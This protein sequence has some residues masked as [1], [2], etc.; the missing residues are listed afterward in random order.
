M[1]PKTPTEEIIQAYRETGSVWAA[2][3]RLG[4]CGQSVW[5]RLRSMGYPMQK[6]LWTAAEIEELRA[7]VGTMPLG[8]VAKRLGR[9]YT[10]VATRASKLGLKTPTGPWRTWKPPRGAGFDKVSM[11]KHVAALTAGS[12]S[13]W[14]FCR[15]RGLHIDPFIKAFERHFPDQLAAYRASH[16]IGPARTCPNCG[17]DFHAMTTRQQ[18]CSRRCQTEHRANHQY[19]GGNR[20][21]AIG[22]RERQCQLCLRT[23]ERGLSVHHLYGREND[24]EHA[25]LIAVC[26]GCHHLISIATGFAFLE[27]TDGWERLIEFVLQRRLAD[28][29]R[30]NVAGIQT[31]VD[32]DWLTP[33]EMESEG[34]DHA[35]AH[36]G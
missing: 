17:V 1:T 20:N 10:S 32:I 18:T 21:Q 30:E 24:P 3:K 9:P 7:L 28:K 33:E 31:Y 16:A 2:G 29:P 13:L 14:Q 19:F 5:E 34:G 11:R 35:E 36:T 25:A 22:L 4:L 23:R 12:L 8:E 6:M 26:A 15:Q 27:T